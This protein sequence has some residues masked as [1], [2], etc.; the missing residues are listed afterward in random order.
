MRQTYSLAIFVLLLCGLAIAQEPGPGILTP[1]PP[2]TLDPW[3]L[4]SKLVQQIAPDYPAK[5]RSSNLH[6]DVIIKVFVDQTGNVESTTWIVMPDA[7]AILAFAALQ[8]IRQ[9]KYQPTLV[10][11]N[12]RPVSS[13]VALRFRANAMPNVEILTQSEN[14]TP[15]IDPARLITARKLRISSGVAESNLV[16]KVYPAYPIEARDNGVEGDVLFQVMIGK[17]DGAITQI[18]PVSGH[19]LLVLAA[20]DA[21]RQ[22]KYRPYLLNGEPVDVETTITIKFHL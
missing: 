12:P 15:Q 1:P 20:L 18:H 17:P 2:I 16:H 3:V 5:I 8:A 4:H 9:W 6:G 19:P 7:P 10:D 21:I 22:W 11:G 13:W 14:S